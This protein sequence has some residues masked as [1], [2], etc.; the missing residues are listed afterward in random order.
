MY[1]IDQ[2]SE[3]VDAMLD[4]LAQLGVI[5]IK[6]GDTRESDQ[7][8]LRHSELETTWPTLA[9][10]LNS[11][12]SFRNQVDDW[13]SRGRPKNALIKENEL[14]EARS[15]LDRNELERAFTESS[16]YQELRHI[17]RNRARM[18]WLGGLAI[19]AAV[20]AYY[21]IC[22]ALEA[23]AAGDK[24]RIA[25]EASEWSASA[26]SISTLAVASLMMT[27]DPLEVHSAKKLLIVQSLRNLL[28][29]Q[30]DESKQV[31]KDAWRDF[32]AQ[33]CEDGKPSF[34]WFRVFLRGEPSTG[35]NAK[36]RNKELALILAAQKPSPDAIRALQT[37]TV[38]LKK[39]I[40]IDETRPIIE[41][42]KPKVMQLAHKVA[43][44]IAIEAERRSD[45]KRIEP[46]RMAFWRLN[47]A[48]IIVDDENRRKTFADALASWEEMG[49]LPSKEIVESL[50]RGAKQFGSNPP[51]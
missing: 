24:E 10:W 31:A 21:A 13:N 43:D 26:Q 32:E 40:V 14:D 49:G 11:R 17:E 39:Y 8:W 12:L 33:L 1:D 20:V 29:A 50:K 19:A 36:P 4:R 46:Y 16:R 34:L 25:H 35:S 27:E 9:N 48:L 37:I 5:R 28:F 7:I 44:Q 47:T 30:D 3:R 18:W 51:D 23:K 45:L 42:M 6:A 22:R 2:S 15:Y 41:R 38:D